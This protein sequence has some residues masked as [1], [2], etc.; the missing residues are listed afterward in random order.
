M[1]ANTTYRSGN[2]ELF[3]RLLAY[4]LMAAV[5][6]TAFECGRSEGADEVLE[7]AAT[8][9]VV[10]IY[11]HL[12]N[13]T[14]GEEANRGLVSE[15]AVMQF[16]GRDKEFGKVASYSIEQVHWKYGFTIVKVRTVRD[17][18]QYK[19]AVLFSGRGFKSLS[20][21]TIEPV[22]PKPVASGDS[23]P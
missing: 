3:L 9:I 18:V 12:K 15:G 13:G 10:T 20:L 4:A 1:D 19:E 6:F 22:K 11:E 2:K 17:G 21:G 8:P 16:S 5:V 14:L 7:A 23:Q